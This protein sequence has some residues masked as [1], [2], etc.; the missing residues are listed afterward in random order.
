MDSDSDP[1]DSSPSAVR[2]VHRAS[3]GSNRAD[4]SA[5]AP[6]YPPPVFFGKAPNG[7]SDSGVVRGP[8][9]HGGRVATMSA[10]AEIK[11]YRLRLFSGKTFAPGGNFRGQGFS[12]VGAVTH[13]LSP[14]NGVGGPPGRQWGRGGRC[15]LGK[16]DNR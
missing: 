10:G 13:R 1:P 6:E 4:K 16:G 9:S 11:L 2:L 5:L 7:C 15:N 8:E 14:T 3:W 12:A